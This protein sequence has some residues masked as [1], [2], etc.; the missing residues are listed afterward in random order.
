MDEVEKLIAAEPVITLLIA[1]L[2]NLIDK[3]QITDPRLVSQVKKSVDMLT[4]V[5][6]YLEDPDGSPGDLN[7]ERL[8]TIY[9]LE[10]NIDIFL[11]RTKFQKRGLV[12][13]D[14]RLKYVHIQTLL[15]NQ[16]MKKLVSDLE[17]EW[18][19]LRHPSSKYAKLGKAILSALNKRSGISGLEGRVKMLAELI[20]SDYS[21]PFPIPVMDVEGSATTTDL[22]KIYNDVEVKDHFDCRAW[23]AVAQEFDKSQLLIDIIKQVR[24]TPGTREEMQERF[25]ERQLRNFLIG[26]RYLV[27]LIDV[28]T[29]DLWEIVKYAFP[30]SS[31]GSRVISSFRAADVVRYPNIIFY[32]RNPA[33][34]SG[35]MR[36]S[37]AT[38]NVV[39]D[40]NA[41]T[42][43]QVSG[44]DRDHLLEKKFDEKTNTRR[45]GAEFVSGSCNIQVSSAEINVVGDDIVTSEQPL[46]NEDPDQL[47]QGVFDEETDIVG[48]K[49]KVLELAK[50]TLSDKH[51]VVV[52]VGAAGSGKTTLVKTIY[53]SSLMRQSFGCRAWVNVYLSVHYYDM[54]NV[55]ISILNQVTKLAKD[56]EELLPHQLETKLSDTLSGKKFLIVLDDVHLP[57]AW[58][59]FRRILLPKS[60]SGSRVILI[61]RKD[62]VAKSVSPTV[63]RLRSLDK[64]EIRELFSKMARKY[65]S[66]DLINMQEEVGEICR[67]LPLGIC[68]LGGLFSTRNYPSNSEW[69]RVFKKA[70]F[71]EAQSI[72]PDLLASYIWKL[73]YKILSPRFR[74]Y[75]HYLCLF[76]KSDEVPVRRLFH[77]WLAERLVTPSGEEELEELV[78]KDIEVLENMRIIQVVRRRSNGKPK[79]CNV[80]S[81]LYDT[82]CQN[83]H[84]MGSFHVNSNIS[85]STSNSRKVCIRRFAE[86][87]DIQNNP[88]S[89][90][91]GV[92][93]LHSFISF[94]TRKDDK[95]SEEL[96]NF[97]NKT[98]AKEGI[99][100]LRVLDLE[101]VYKP[102]L[103]ETLGKLKLLRY[104]GLRWTFLDSIPKS[105]GDLPCLETLDLK[106]TN[107]TK[108][109]MSIWRSKTLRHLYMNHLHFKTSTGM[110]DSLTNLQTL[111]GLFICNIN[112]CKNDWLKSLSSIKN[113][114][115]TCHTTSFEGISEQIR[116]HTSL[117][118]LKLQL[119]NNFGEPSGFNRVPI[120]EF[121][122]LTELYL[123]GMLPR[124]FD[125]SRF[126]PKLQIL[127]LS[128]S[129][130]SN[131]PMPILGKLEDL[132]TL[133]L[134]AHSYIGERLT[135]PKDA[136]RKLHV[137]KLWVLKELKHWTI[138]DNAMRALK[139]LEIRYCQKL[140]QIDGLE[141]VRTLKEIILTNMEEDF[142]KR[143]GEK[144][145]VTENNW[146]IRPTWRPLKL[147][148]ERIICFRLKL[149]YLG[150]DTHSCQQHDP[151]EE[152][153]DD[154]GASSKVKRYVEEMG[155]QGIGFEGFAVEA[156]EVKDAQ[157]EIDVSAARP[158]SSA[159]DNNILRAHAF[160]QTF[161]CLF[162]DLILSFQDRDKSQ[163]FF[164]KLSHEDAFNVIAIELGFMY[165]LLYTKATAIHTRWGFG[166]RI[167][168]FTLTCMV[169]LIFFFAD[170]NNY[171]KTRPVYG[172]ES[173]RKFQS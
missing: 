168:T 122:N 164:Q 59:D 166:L 81:S 142:V 116:E 137:L 56:E 144:R 79:T 18:S 55:L 163:S 98:I 134:F 161:K 135:C 128:L 51:S 26:K 50:L 125:I 115:L 169:F 46:S 124:R 99:G 20:L 159:D 170:K 9:R 3:N 10:D 127:T 41:T 60:S 140:K 129:Q 112:C 154:G 107:I 83:S 73:A 108:L 148:S 80:T 61:T 11:V 62:T 38:T 100:L 52:V 97:L 12:F 172:S 75:I 167:I 35:D 22:Q 105:I 43:Q 145:I 113:L 72:S 17:K 146:T 156:E 104:V 45:N 82:F 78:N 69:S 117:Q 95:P 138:D 130:L 103:P 34:N 153:D 6:K 133:R 114:G 33:L 87:I 76:P 58:Y 86:H 7:P 15:M 25:D 74:A 42:E 111:R 2:E 64:H 121:K 91:E 131:D 151:G 30:N 101:K 93:H 132:N 44:Q 29:P 28:R 110:L 158:E 94:N 160:F 40:D 147:V 157:V 102:V 106:H 49:D 16:I 54:K 36:V 152:E 31:H 39:F 139:Q 171:V 57:G 37:Y 27:I 5:E 67:G 96:G 4:K 165:D 141:N 77:L 162:A 21:S 84:D 68:V 126:P 92:K 24:G 173:I 47:L 32:G 150:Y 63:L 13:A 71:G 89:S 19:I 1:K 109:P 118:S 143:L 149:Q 123:L 88:P 155:A 136:F 90:D 70:R 53:D 65:K 23:V 119:I 48:L 85:N 66:S 120:D 14:F 8:Q